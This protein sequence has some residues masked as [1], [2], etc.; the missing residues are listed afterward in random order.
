MQL[1]KAQVPQDLLSEEMHTSDSLGSKWAGLY[2][3][4]K[5]DGNS[6]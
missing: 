2:L 3:Y 4:K 6:L 1:Q 5:L